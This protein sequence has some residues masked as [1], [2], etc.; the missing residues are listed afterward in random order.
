MD[1]R[2]GETSLLPR[3]ITLKENERRHILWALE[4]T[5]GKIHGTEGA[6][7]LLDIHPNTLAFRMKKL[8]IKKPVFAGRKNAPLPAPG[9]NHLPTD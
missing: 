2:I 3:P 7:R 1:V 6:A 9:E 4:E 5:R 8:G